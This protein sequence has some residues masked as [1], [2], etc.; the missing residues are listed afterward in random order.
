MQV[1]MA[2]HV[3]SNMTLDHFDFTVLTESPGSYKSR[4]RKAFMASARGEQ[5]NGDDIPCPHER[6]TANIRRAYR[7]EAQRAG[8]NAD[9]L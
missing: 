7:E 9:K 2:E 6:N 4:I 5:Q 1:V 3:R 8:A